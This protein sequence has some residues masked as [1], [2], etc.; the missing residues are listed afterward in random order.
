MNQPVHLSE[1]QFSVLLLEQGDAATRAHL[2]DCADCSVELERVRESLTSFHALGME[3]AELRSS[4]LGPVQVSARDGRR[5]PLVWATATAV[6]VGVIFAGMHHLPQ[7]GTKIE[8][9]AVLPATPMAPAVAAVK[10][11]APV[12]VAV[13]AAATTPT[14]GRPAVDSR[15]EADNRLLAAIDH[16]LSNGE[17]TLLVPVSELRTDGGKTQ[18]RLN[19]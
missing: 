1:E 18:R 11:A 7:T 10:A 8:M 17:P 19:D 16:E 12:R 4:T 9:A 14:L 3:W 13:K 15:I 5:M 6:V 2:A